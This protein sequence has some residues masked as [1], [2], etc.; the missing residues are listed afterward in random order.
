MIT[1][2]RPIVVRDSIRF[3]HPGHDKPRTAVILVVQG[4]NLVAIYGRGTLLDREHV[5]VSFPS[6]YAESIGLNKVTYFYGTSIVRVRRASVHP[7]GHCPPGVWE[8]LNPFALKH[9]RE[10][11]SIVCRPG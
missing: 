3:Q 7:V 1:I 9:L 10:M 2:G 6:S 5:R 11:H 4:E 8:D